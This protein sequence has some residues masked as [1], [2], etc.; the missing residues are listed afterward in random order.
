[1]EKEALR[2]MF[3][4]KIEEILADLVWGTSSGPETG[5]GLAGLIKEFPEEE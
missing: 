5:E 4:D 3:E 1:M 2:K